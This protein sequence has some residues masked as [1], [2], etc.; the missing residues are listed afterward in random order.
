MR[1]SA[2]RDA[3]VIFGWI[4]AGHQLGAASAAFF[5]G[6]MRT[7]E[8]RYLEAFV[9]AGATGLLAAGMSLFIGRSGPALAPASAS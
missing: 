3:P 8:G 7:L 6:I 9:I 4:A 2:R 5:A 1:P